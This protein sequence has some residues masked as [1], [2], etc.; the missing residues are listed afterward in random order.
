MKL[1]E[2]RLCFCRIIRPI[3]VVKQNA[4]AKRKSPPMILNS[5]PNIVLISFNIVS[6]YLSFLFIP[7]GKKFDR[8]KNAFPATKNRDQDFPCWKLNV[9]G[10]VGEFE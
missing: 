3:N 1:V 7:L 10:F 5:T 8:R 9:C 6:Q 4:T 2:L